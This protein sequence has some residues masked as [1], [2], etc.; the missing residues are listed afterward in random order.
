MKLIKQPSN[1][2]DQWNVFSPF[3]N[4]LRHFFDR[5]G[6]PAWESTL[7]KEWN[8]SLNVTE[9]ESAIHVSVELPGVDRE[10]VNLQFH[11]GVLTVSGEKKYEKS[12]EDEES[13]RQERYFGQ[14]YRSVSIPTDIDSE[15]IKAQYKDGILKITLPKTEVSKPKQILIDSE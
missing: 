3:G 5:V 15:N 13:K 7:S 2:L 11:D 14:F 4:D 6:F 8:P 10:N 12:S 1:V 9:D